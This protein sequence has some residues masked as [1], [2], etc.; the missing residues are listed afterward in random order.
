VDL[1][2][3][4]MLTTAIASEPSGDPYWLSVAGVPQRCDSPESSPHGMLSMRD[5]FH[6]CALLLLLTAKWR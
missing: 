3:S 1:P 2:E 4:L 5:R 6:A